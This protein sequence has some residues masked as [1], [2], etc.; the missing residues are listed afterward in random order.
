M[1][2][3]HRLLRGPAACP[4]LPP[5]RDPP[6]PALQCGVAAGASAGAAR[7]ELLENTSE[8]LPTT[9]ALPAVSPS[10]SALPCPVLPGTWSCQNGVSSWGSLTLR[11]Q[12]CFLPHPLF[13]TLTCKSHNTNH[14]KVCSSVA[15]EHV[16]SVGAT[17][18]RI[19]SHTPPLES[20]FPSFLYHPDAP[21][22]PS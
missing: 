20:S 13:Q 3:T 1:G 4:P 11:L 12:T 19:S 2:C 18:T 8:M 21:A 9:S 16:L 17:I 15:F 10:S 6:V 14:F 5:R 7:V 22:P